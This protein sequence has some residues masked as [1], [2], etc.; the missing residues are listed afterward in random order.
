MH[1]H[2]KH[3][4]FNSLTVTM[5]V[6]IISTKQLICSWDYSSNFTSNNVSCKVLSHEPLFILSINPVRILIILDF[7]LSWL[8]VTN[9]GHVKSSQD[10]CFTLSKIN[11]LVE[12]Q[13]N[14]QPRAFFKHQ[15]HQDHLCTVTF[16]KPMTSAIWGLTHSDGWKDEGA[17]T[18]FQH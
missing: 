12:T 17:Y 5:Q 10:L 2:L 9:E 13:Q 16:P 18:P 4:F 1:W 6:V 3:M 8:M 11:S 15:C 7:K 14:I